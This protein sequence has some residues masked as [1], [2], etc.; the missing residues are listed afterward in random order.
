[1][2]Y[3]RLLLGVLVSTAL[4]G[5]ILLPILGGN[6]AAAPYS[7]PGDIVSSNA[8]AW[9]GLRAYSAATA[10]SAA[11]NVCTPVDAAC[12]DLSTN[13]TTG[14]LVVTTIGGSDCSIVVCTIKKLYDQ[15]Q[16]SKCSSA[17]CDIAQPVESDR[18]I[19]SVNCVGGKPCIIWTSGNLLVTGTG[20]ANIASLSVSSV[21]ER[22]GGATNYSNVT[23][24]DMSSGDFQFLFSNSANTML[25]YA[26]NTTLT[27][28][29]NDNAFHAMQG[30]YNGASSALYIDGSNTAGNSGSN[31]LSDTHQFG[32]G[33]VT[34][35]GLIGKI[36]EAGWWSGDKTASFSALNTNQHAY[37]GF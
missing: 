13:A 22:T 15:T 37:W 3:L 8:I 6:S 32:M 7:G 25:L 18:P 31:S 34:G 11:A 19:L 21:A 29:A 1:M 33:V 24:W 17:T 12:A 14:D 2:K 9:W 27:A 10:G 5:Q 16:G 23:A 20:Y 30:H 36:A 4:H 28:A 26:G 35:N